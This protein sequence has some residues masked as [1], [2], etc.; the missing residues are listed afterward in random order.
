MSDI[1]KIGFES[2]E[3]AEAEIR[4]IIETAY[5][6]VPKRNCKPTRCYYSEITKKWHLSSQPTIVEYPKNK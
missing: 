2:Q 4:R 6:P 3:D 1:D 5:N